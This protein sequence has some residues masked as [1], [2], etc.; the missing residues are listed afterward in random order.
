MVVVFT[1]TSRKQTI[2]KTVNGQVYVYERTLYFDRTLKNTK[3]HY[4]YVGKEVDGVPK[5]VR[6][7]LPRR[8]LVSGPFIPIMRVV[9]DMGIE[10]I[11]KLHLTEPEARHELEFPYQRSSG[12]CHR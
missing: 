7:V 2:K 6:S 4:K 3:Y 8:S 12:R 9:R 1:I 11:L 5:R 10:D